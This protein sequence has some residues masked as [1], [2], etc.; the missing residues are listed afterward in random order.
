MED[1]A[2]HSTLTVF[3]D[4]IEGEFWGTKGGDFSPCSQNCRSPHY[5]FKPPPINI[6]YSKLKLWDLIVVPKQLPDR[7]P[8]LNKT[9]GWQMVAQVSFL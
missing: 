5:T 2:T 6:Q 7:S 8:K 3:S 9:T 4:R 1:I